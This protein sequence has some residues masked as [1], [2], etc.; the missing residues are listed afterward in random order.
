MRSRCSSCCTQTLWVGE[1]RG[2]VLGLVAEVICV[3]GRLCNVEC[4]EFFTSHRVERKPPYLTIIDNV[5]HPRCVVVNSIVRI[6]DGRSWLPIQA[7]PVMLGG[8]GQ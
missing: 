6:Y 7:T 4:L 8:H 5:S 3:F 1:Q 2:N